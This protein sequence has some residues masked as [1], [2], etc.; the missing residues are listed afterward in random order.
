M[1]D[2]IETAPKLPHQSPVQE[3]QPSGEGLHSRNNRR[4]EII[5]PPYICHKPS[6]A[7]VCLCDFEP[8]E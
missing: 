4:G 1:S 6:P 2:A 8:Q 3:M 5:P 7:T